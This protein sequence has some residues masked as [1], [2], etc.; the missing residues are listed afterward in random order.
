MV[1]V[2]IAQLSAIWWVFT[3]VC[4]LTP[5]TSLCL[6]AWRMTAP[7]TVIVVSA[8]IGLYGRPTYGLLVLG[9]IWD[10]SFGLITCKVSRKGCILCVA[11]LFALFAALVLKLYTVFE[12]L[13][14]AS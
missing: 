9:C 13:F 6:E 3:I 4:I 14:L 12:S 1:A 2:G 11:V 5:H 8:G 10:W 7:V